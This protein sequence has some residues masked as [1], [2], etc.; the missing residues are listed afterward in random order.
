MCGIFGYIGDIPEQDYAIAHTLLTN[1]FVESK[2]RGK[3]AS[4]FA[5]IRYDLP[6]LITDKR[7]VD[8]EVFINRSDKFKVL[9]KKMP[10]IFIGHTRATT[11]S[12]PK[13]NRNNHPF[14]SNRLALVHNG[15][16]SEWEKI[17]M[18]MNLTLR[19]ETDSEILLRALDKYDNIVDGCRS[20]L[21]N[22]ED[23]KY[24]IAVFNHGAKGMKE[25]YLFRNTQQ[26]CYTFRVDKW[27]A[28]FFASVENIIKN[29]LDKTFGSNNR[30]KLISEYEMK[31]PTS[32]VPF[33]LYRMNHGKDGAGKLAVIEHRLEPPKSNKTYTTITGC[34]TGYSSTPYVGP[35]SQSL[36]DDEPSLGIEFGDM[37][38]AS[39]AEKKHLP[40]ST[41]SR[42]NSLE[43]VL[44][45]SNRVIA[46]L[47]TESY[48][49]DF[50]YEHFMKW[51]LDV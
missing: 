5:A 17:A 28:L 3:D 45:E 31:E 15:R 30:A 29:S 38:I 20:I 27:N 34:G 49:D 19:S 32:T 42:V 9:K 8:S 44:N 23:A 18:R 7:N 22:I 33:T 13:R 39:Q 50:E 1:L 41:L 36:K 35:V 2:S 4:G 47:Q 48:M 12:D 26:P 43:E 6:D 46:L 51:M 21:D 24:A 14:L 37:V 25:L 10:H 16:V 40:D 11:G